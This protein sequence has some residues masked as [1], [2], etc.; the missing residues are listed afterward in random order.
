MQLYPRPFQ[1]LCPL[2]PNDPIKRLKAGRTLHPNPHPPP[3]SSHLPPPS[4]PFFHPALRMPALTCWGAL[5]VVHR[6]TPPPL[7]HSFTAVSLRAKAT[8][9]DS[10]ARVV[11]TQVFSRADSASPVVA[12]PDRP[13]DAATATVRDET[14]YMFPLPENAAVC[15]FECASS[16]GAV[17][18]GVAKEK[19]EAR[20]EFDSA[21]QAGKSA[22]LLEQHMADVF[23]VSV[24]NLRGGQVTT[25]ITYI[26]E[27]SHNNES[28]EIRFTLLSKHLHE[29]YGV[30]PAPNSS[31]SSNVATFVANTLGPID[32]QADEPSVTIEIGMGGAITSI[33]SPSHTSVNVSIG[34]S[35]GAAS[36]PFDPCR[37]L[38]R[39]DSNN[40]YLDQEMVLVVKSKTA[41]QPRCLMERHPQHNTYAL[42]LTMVPRFALNEIRTEIIILVDRSG[43]MSGDK[44]RSASLALQLLLRSMPA[45]AGLYFNIIGFGSS[46]ASLFP[47]SVEYTEHSMKEAEHYVENLKADMGGTELRAAVEAVF[48]KRRK[49]MPTQLFVLTD[50]EIWSADSLFAFISGK[51]KE[52]EQ[53]K[54]RS[55]QT[56]FAR[57]FSLG[58]GRDV[59][60]NLVEGMARHGGGFAQF[61][62]DSNEK[63]QPKIIKMLKAAVMPPVQDYTIDWTGG[64][65]WSA[66]T[67]VAPAAEKPVISLFGTESKPQ[68]IPIASPPGLIQSAPFVVPT[69]W[70]GTRFHSYAILDASIPPPTCV[71]ITGTSPDGPLELEVPVK[72]L[73]QPGETL[74]VLAARKL[75]RDLED[76]KSFMDQDMPASESDRKAEIV[77]VG[78]KYGLTSKYTSF[79]AVEERATQRQEEAEKS[80]AGGSAPHGQAAESGLDS[81]GAEDSEWEAVVV[82]Y[83]EPILEENE[84]SDDDMGFGL[85]DGGS[86]TPA[87]G[88]LLANA[89]VDHAMAVAYEAESCL[90]DYDDDVEDYGQALPEESSAPIQE[91]YQRQLKVAAVPSSSIR[92][93]SFAL[94]AP[95]GAAVADSVVS[96]SKSAAIT[97]E[98]Q[99]N[100]LVRLQM[101]DGSFGDTVAPIAGWMGK[102]EE[103]IVCQL[104][105]AILKTPPPPGALDNRA[106]LLAAF[107]CAL[108]VTV[109]EKRLV[110]LKDSWEMMGEKAKKVAVGKVGKE[111]WEWLL[112]VSSSIV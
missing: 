47:A 72:V 46:F 60:H 8:L 35:T 30:Q 3:P 1:W 4:L 97:P 34:T 20:K 41:D 64:N 79:V 43:S 32:L 91:L 83:K 48:E 17:I 90:V 93:S 103:E 33:Q 16:D 73:S 26:Q 87:A 74:H 76:M 27:L 105:D 82:E 65:G 100:S 49:D 52:A 62:V 21:V 39:L 92:S 42:G 44:I 15:G 31:N 29:R 24:G 5:V 36:E 6:S 23:Q 40:A 53:I 99:L 18:R 51:V 95:V 63:L 80:S 88:R 77:R 14:I 55:G 81:Q 71:R 67:V 22:G 109:L 54:L 89:Y 96:A 2:S 59:S 61:V 107:A 70:P 58:I 78:V 9:V 38:V 68:P 66:P 108:A 85:F 104:D 11:I 112:M 45:T 75:I 13:V 19:A 106:S 57:V 37:A 56:A 12:D 98:A 84:E 10:G 7:S 101:F 94:P 102:S 111:G 28:D 69:L 110:V 50:G 86:P 25:R